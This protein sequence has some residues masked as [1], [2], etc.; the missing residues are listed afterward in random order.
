M[1]LNAVISQFTHR[2]SFQKSAYSVNSFAFGITSKF[3]ANN[4]LKWLFNS[5]TIAGGIGWDFVN[6]PYS[7]F[8]N[9]TYFVVE[10]SKILK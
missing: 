6:N 9:K 10:Y 8:P 5:I 1:Y 3:M 4:G 7:L 2:F